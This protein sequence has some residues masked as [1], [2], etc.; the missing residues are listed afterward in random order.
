[1]AVGW[2][3]FDNVDQAMNRVAKQA[4]PAIANALDLARM[5]AEVAAAAPS[6]AAA[7]SEDERTKVRAALG[8][9][10]GAMQKLLTQQSGDEAAIAILGAMADD[11]AQGLESLA[12]ADAVLAFAAGERDIIELRRAELASR[13]SADGSLARNRDTAKKLSETV[14]E[15]VAAARADAGTAT[16]AVG[17]EIGRGRFLLLGIAGA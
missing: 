13:A 14:A 6:L 2:L 5:S 15:I 7:A 8:E 12:K 4:V 1:C 10:Q 11:M 9:K 3:S 17:T 16:E